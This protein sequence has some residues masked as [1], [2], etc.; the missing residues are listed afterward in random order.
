MMKKT[1]KKLAIFEVLKINKKPVGQ[2][3]TA[4]GF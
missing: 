1:L 2:V 3:V 4:A